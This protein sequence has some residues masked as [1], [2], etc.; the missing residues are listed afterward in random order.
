MSQDE[1]NAEIK[2]LEKQVQWLLKR[3]SNDEKINDRLR[4]LKGQFKS[5][6]F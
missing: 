3:G 4:E 1:I 5:I 2:E 6:L